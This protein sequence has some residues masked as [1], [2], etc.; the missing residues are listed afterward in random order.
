[1]GTQRSVPRSSGFCSVPG[2]CMLR[3]HVMCDPGYPQ[4]GCMNGWVCPDR[5]KAGWAC[6]FRRVPGKGRCLF[7]P[8][9]ATVWHGLGVAGWCVDRHLA[10]G[11][12]PALGHLMCR[13]QAGKHPIATPGP[14]Q[15][16]HVITIHL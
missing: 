5:D 6:T 4:D 10:P 3:P 16:A 15:M 1:M 9:L 12:R 13:R 11:L 2:V 7:R 8:V 14:R